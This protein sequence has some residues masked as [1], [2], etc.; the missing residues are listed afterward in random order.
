M[1]TMIMTTIWYTTAQGVSKQENFL[2]FSKK[3]LTPWNQ[4][5][6]LNNGLEPKPKHPK[7]SLKPKTIRKNQLQE[8]ILKGS[9]V[10]SSH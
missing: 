6:S 5:Q 3:I 1:L 2:F 9:F 4:N 7:T 8:I 10:R